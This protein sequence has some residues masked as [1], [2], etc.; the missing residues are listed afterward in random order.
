MA[1]PYFTK[2]EVNW[3]KENRNKIGNTNEV[4][5]QFI[6]KFNKE[7]SES[8]YYYICRRN[9]IKSNK[10]SNRFIYTKEIKDFIKENIDKYSYDQLLEILQKKYNYT[11]DRNAL[12]KWCNDNLKLYKTDKTKFLPR[13]EIGHEK[14]SQTGA[15]YVK[16]SDIMQAKKS[17]NTYFNYRR[18]TSIM[19]ETYHN[20]VVDDETH[21][22]IQLDDNHNNFDK[23]NLFLI[24][25]KV[26]NRYLGFYNGAF[27]E[28]YY[29]NVRL[30]KLHLMSLELEEIVKEERSQ[31]ND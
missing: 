15:I 14:V 22:V 11:N 26:Y 10:Y 25:K 1:N 16:V 23:D 24:S 9:N 31:N 7:L 4:I 12:N 3:I 30:K 5:R 21:I 2:E 17:R 6:E 18:K 27:S 13:A 29:E 20:V 8:S 19:Y 28:N